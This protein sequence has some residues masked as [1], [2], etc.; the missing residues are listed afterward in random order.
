[1]TCSAIYQG[2]FEDTAGCHESFSVLQCYI[3]G[4]YVPCTE[5][6]CMGSYWET[7]PSGDQSWFGLG[8]NPQS[9]LC[10]QSCAAKKQQMLEKN[11]CHVWE[12]N[13]SDVH[14]S[15]EGYKIYHWCF[16]QVQP[17]YLQESWLQETGSDLLC[18]QPRLSDVWALFAYSLLGTCCKLWKWW[19]NSVSVFLKCWGIFPVELM[20]ICVKKH[21]IHVYIKI[22]ALKSP[23]RLYN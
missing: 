12:G 17:I 3:R 22:S 19:L 1:M 13:M 18:M 10:C 14:F 9:I 8:F 6:F 21:P 20:K 15:L 5:T 16:S 4:K 11:S 23:I 7:D 2:K